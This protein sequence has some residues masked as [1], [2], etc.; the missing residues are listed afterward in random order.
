[1]KWLIWASFVMLAVRCLN[2]R[3]GREPKRLMVKGGRTGMNLENGAKRP[4]DGT[5]DTGDLIRKKTL[6]FSVENL[7]L[8]CKAWCFGN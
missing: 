6:F 8:N 7:S 1:M 4:E 3:L 5:E 2:P